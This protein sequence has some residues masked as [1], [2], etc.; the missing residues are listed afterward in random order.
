MLT[1]KRARTRAELSSIYASLEALKDT[2]KASALVASYKRQVRSSSEKSSGSNPGFLA[3]LGLGSI[4]RRADASNSE[5]ASGNSEAKPTALTVAGAD[6]R[7]WVLK[8]AQI[9]ARGMNST[10]EVRF[11]EQDNR[12]ERQPEDPA[13]GAVHKL[14][15][16][17]SDVTITGN[18]DLSAIVAPHVSIVLQ[19]I[20][21][22]DIYLY[23]SEFSEIILD[24]VSE[25]E[26]YGLFIVAENAKVERFVIYS[27]AERGKQGT[28]GDI[29]HFGAHGLQCGELEM[30]NKKF[31]GGDLLDWWAH[32]NQEGNQLRFQRLYSRGVDLTNSMCGRVFAY[33]CAFSNIISFRDARVK[34]LLKLE[35]CT[36]AGLRPPDRND[37]ASRG[38]CPP[39]SQSSDTFDYDDIANG[40]DR[41]GLTFDASRADIGALVFRAIDGQDRGGS[42]FPSSNGNKWKSNGWMNFA[43]ARARVL[44]MDF[45]YFED[46]PMLRHRLTGFRYDSLQW[47]NLGCLPDT[48]PVGKSKGEEKQEPED[49]EIKKAHPDRDKLNSS[50]K[51]STASNPAPWRQVTRWLEA[52]LDIDLREEFKGQPWTLAAKTFHVEGDFTQSNEIMYLRE[53]YYHRSLRL[54]GGDPITQ[55]KSILFWLLGCMNWLHGF[56]YRLGRPFILMI[57]VW[58]LGAAYYQH[59]F[60]AGY[61]LPNPAS[62]GIE[63]MSEAVSQSQAR[64]YPAAKYPK[65][66]PWIYSLDVMIPVVH[67]SQEVFWVPGY[68][69]RDAE[70]RDNLES[71]EENKSVWQRVLSW[72]EGDGDGLFRLWLVYWAQ[73]IIGYIGTVV[74]GLGLVGYLER[75]PPA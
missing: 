53:T 69:T 44:E 26:W 64:Q 11:N 68:G 74:I 35:A 48:T 28:H 14:T 42:K 9:A 50:D 33:N 55:A 30:Y 23:R 71:A 27:G 31:I 16:N 51:K 24:G 65:F 8:W 22:D 46:K 10:S 75:R 63:Q 72:R 1:S 54:R 70:Q 34:E 3:R 49:E 39:R 41:N 57:A 37:A 13:I 6:I 73:I 2:K 29:L 7:E 21:V 40:V 45:K 47:P 61:F 32:N 17:I 52:Q 67:F 20:N 62:G 38:E 60:N 5:Q 56:G 12:A 43:N 19:N 58:L 66:N 25:S 15:L 59:S 18:L 36:F 4:W